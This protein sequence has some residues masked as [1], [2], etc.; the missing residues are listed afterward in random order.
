MPFTNELKFLVDEPYHG[1]RFGD[2]VSAP[3]GAL[4][5]LTHE[6][7]RKIM[8]ALDVKTIGEFAADES[9]TTGLFAAAGRP[10]AKL[11]DLAIE[12][13][14]SGIGSRVALMVERD[15]IRRQVDVAIQDVGR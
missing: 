6:Q 5:G 3:V 8:A 2:I 14:R 15:G 1:K 12:L 4:G 7:G 11:A 10:V 9:R 13:E